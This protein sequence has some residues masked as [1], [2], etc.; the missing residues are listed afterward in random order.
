MKLHFSSDNYDYFKYNGKSNV[1]IGAFEHRKDKYYFYKLSRRNE[2]EDYTQFLVSNFVENNKVWSGDLLRKEALDIHHS[3]MKVIQSLSYM[4][5]EDCAKLKGECENPNDLLKTDG[6][7][8]VLLTM[9]LHREICFETLC[10]M[11]SVL[12][13]LSVWRSKILDTIRFPEINRKI[14]KYT[15]FIPFDREKMKS[16]MIERFL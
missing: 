8:P 13:F 9:V 16:I 12:G 3:R 2:V 15:P 6:D 7:Y 10:I 11:N 1:S 14:V 5:T 4:F